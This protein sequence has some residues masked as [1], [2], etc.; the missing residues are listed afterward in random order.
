M[1]GS[2]PSD[3]P[4]SGSS[5]SGSSPT[6]DPDADDVSG[7]LSRRTIIRLLVALGLGI[8]IIV[9]LRTFVS[10]VGSWVGGDDDTPTA[11]PVEDAVGIGDDLLAETDS[12]ER[13]RSAE[14]TATDGDTWPF[15]VVVD[16]ENASDRY[17][18]L[19]LGAVTTRDGT[20]VD[21]G[22]ATD[23]LVPGES[24]TLATTW[25]L[26]EGGSP[27]SIA[28]RAE[29]GSGTPEVVEREVRLRGIAVEG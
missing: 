5:P 14:V 3:S 21:G 7:G 29:L 22:A 13:L 19:E 23:R 16:V 26:P 9:E 27:R 4:S 20:V 28:V 2:P 18:R 25:S 17:Y 15:T 12:V 8:P 6:D 11:T 24:T 10:L 1:S